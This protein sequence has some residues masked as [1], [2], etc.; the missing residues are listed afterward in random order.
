[1]NETYNVSIKGIND[2][3]GGLS[4]LGIILGFAAMYILFVGE[5]DG[6]D[7]IVKILKDTAYPVE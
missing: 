7:Y 5:P 4:F 3:C 2:V 6:I 1:M